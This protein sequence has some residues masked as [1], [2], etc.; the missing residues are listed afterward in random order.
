MNKMIG[1]VGGVGSYAGLDLIRK[2]YDLT[3]ARSDQEHLPVSM[4]SIPHK[5]LDRSGF[6]AGEIDENPAY[7]IAE[8]ITSLHKTGAEI[9]GIPCN[10]AHAPQIFGTIVK[11]IPGECTVVHMIEE[12]ASYIKE[13]FPDIKKVGV[14]ST[15]GT[16]FSNVYPAT[17]SKFGIE[18]IQPS[19]EMQ[20][21]IVHPAIYD[22]YYGIKAQSNPPTDLAKSHLLFVASSLASLGAEAIILGCTEIPLAIGQDRIG[23]SIVID[24]TSIL[25]RALIKRSRENEPVHS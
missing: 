11:S 19:L 13:N 5:I 22:P 16:Y 18:V 1:I 7:S 9:I 3:G 24:A 4:L 20:T 23:N 12:V 15:N 17:C 8:I 10:T 25:A 21:I 2:I 14:L 6:L